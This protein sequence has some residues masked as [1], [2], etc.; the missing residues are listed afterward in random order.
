MEGELN[1]LH[2][3]TIYR[4]RGTYTYYIKCVD[5]GGN[6][7]F[8]NTTFTVEVDTEWP[9]LTRVY[10]DGDTLKVV[11]DEKANC[12]YSL[13]NCNYNLADGLPMVY[14][15]STKQTVHYVDWNPEVTYYIK[16]EDKRG[17]Q[18]PPNQCQ[19]IVRGSE[20]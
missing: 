8:A 9:E 16:C 3:Q 17:K 13:T 11:T 5:D 1:Y 12:Y 6:A 15:D 7:A 14:E 10:R 4:S 19:L 2:N 20:F 18:P